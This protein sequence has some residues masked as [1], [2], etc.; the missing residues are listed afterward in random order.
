MVDLSAAAWRK[1][2]HSQQG[3]NCVEIADGLPGV[4]PIRDSKDPEGPSLTFTAEDFTAFVQGVK[5]GTF[6]TA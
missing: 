1:S 3:G 4:L 6:T 2:S 5:N